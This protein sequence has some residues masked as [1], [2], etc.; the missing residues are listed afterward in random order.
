MKLSNVIGDFNYKTPT[1]YFLLSYRIY[2]F[3]YN[4]KMTPFN[5]QIRK[6]YFFAIYVHTIKTPLFIYGL[7][8]FN[9][10]DLNG[11]FHYLLKICM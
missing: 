10:V 3:T 5:P 1:N 11:N 6:D 2:Q 7:N 4:G 9:V 8:Y